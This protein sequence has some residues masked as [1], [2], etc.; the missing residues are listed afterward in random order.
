[1]L[2]LCHVNSAKGSSDLRPLTFVL[3]LLHQF[4]NHCLYYAYIAVEKSAKESTSKGNP[5]VG[6]KAYD[7]ER[8]YNSE[9]SKQED[10]LTTDAIAQ[11][12]PVHAA[13]CFGKGEGAD[14]DAR[15]EWSVRLGGNIEL[16]DKLPCVGE[17]GGKGNGFSDPYK[18][19]LKSVYGSNVRSPA[20]KLAVRH[21]SGSVM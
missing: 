4:A 10:W 5:K 7:E 3:R 16:L 14:E 13:T 1:M 15:E 9:A 8:R 17:D 12:S 18:S 11:R 6:C 21:G 19:C 2:A 20:R